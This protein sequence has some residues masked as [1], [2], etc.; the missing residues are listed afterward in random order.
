MMVFP[1]S[2]SPEIFSR[3]HSDKNGL[4]VDEKNEI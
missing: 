2:P 1:R 3:H 4:A